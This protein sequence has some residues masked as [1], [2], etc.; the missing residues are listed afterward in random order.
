M[1]STKLWRMQLMRS[2][3]HGVF[4]IAVI[5]AV[6]VSSPSTNRVSAQAATPAVKV[7]IFTGVSEFIDDAEKARQAAVAKLTQ[8]LLNGHYIGPAA[9][10]GI[11]LVKSPTDAT[12][13]VEITT[14]GVVPNTYPRPQ[15]D[16]LWPSALRQVRATLHVDTYATTIDGTEYF[17]APIS[18]AVVGAEE[19]IAER[20]Y[21]W[22]NDNR[23]NLAGR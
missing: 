14:I 6:I 20:L 2:Q 13:T 9:D 18:G 17:Q 1:R 5:G 7:C 19:N 21:Q 11:Q 8:L 15:N 3:S 10:H 23:A 4:L 12:V 22:V 16:F